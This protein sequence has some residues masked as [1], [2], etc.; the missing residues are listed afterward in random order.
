MKYSLYNGHN[1]NVGIG[2]EN[3][4]SKISFCTPVNPAGQS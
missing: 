1:G 3:N 2:I 4:K